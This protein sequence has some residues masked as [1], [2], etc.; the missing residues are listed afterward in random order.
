MQGKHMQLINGGD[1]LKIEKY[2]ELKIL[3]F[4]IKERYTLNIKIRMKIVD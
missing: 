4:K 1:F 3:E 2:Y